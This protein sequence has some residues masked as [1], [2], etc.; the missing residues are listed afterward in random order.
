MD[1]EVGN[2]SN[3]LFQEGEVRS[4]EWGGGWRCFSGGST[5]CIGGEPGD[6]DG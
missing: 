5:N 4:R 3:L 1:E 6:V 2:S